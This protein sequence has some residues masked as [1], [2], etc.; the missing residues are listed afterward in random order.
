[1]V[2]DMDEFDKRDKLPNTGRVA[3]TGVDKTSK[4][5]DLILLA[6]RFLGTF[7]IWLAVVSSIVLI[8]WNFE[9][10]PLTITTTPTVQ[11]WVHCTDRFFEFDREIT[12]KKYLTV[13]VTQELKDLS[14]GKIHPM[15]AIPPYSGEAGSRVWTYKKEVP[16]A[17]RDGAYEYKPVLTYQVNP[18]K[19]ITKEAPTQKV[20]V[21]CKEGKL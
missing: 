20:L 14:T 6:I 10:D 5:M 13:Y 2:A 18:I 19:T 11:E 7:G 21:N 12:T 4:Q 16:Y 17:F 1:V 3:F 9:E 15:A 8:Y